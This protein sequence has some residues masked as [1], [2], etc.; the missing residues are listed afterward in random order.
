MNTQTKQTEK[1]NISFDY[2][3][4]NIKTIGELILLNNKVG[5]L[6]Q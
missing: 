1:I 4:E 6:R 5:M 3:K 2:I